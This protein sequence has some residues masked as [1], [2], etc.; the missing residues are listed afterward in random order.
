MNFLASAL[1]RVPVLGAG[2]TVMFLPRRVELAAGRAL[3]RLIHAVGYRRAVSRDNVRRCFPELDQ[4]ACERLLKKNYEHFGILM[5]ELLHLFSPFP[6]HYRGYVERNARIEGLEHWER[7]RA[8]GRGAVFIA[9]HLGNWEL[10]VAVGALNGIPVTMVTKHL[11]PEWL[12]RLAERARV[13]TGIEPIYEPRTLPAVLRALRAGKAVG[14]MMD[15]YAGPPIGIP[16][17]FFGVEVGTLA[18]VGTLINRTGTTVVPAFV[19]RDA[20][21]IIH[22]RIEPEL[23]VGNFLRHAEQGDAGQSG[24]RKADVQRTTELLARKVEAWV[25][26][27]PEQWLWTHR[28]FKNVVWPRDLA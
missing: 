8:K 24:S 17:K 23:E 13:S 7:A 18:A 11:K 2:F 15:Q 3:G 16:V 21:G 4:K 25:R 10:M 9:S 26:E 6:G 5:L 27:N 12:H 20:H 19:R 14:F 28:R 22:V 1:L